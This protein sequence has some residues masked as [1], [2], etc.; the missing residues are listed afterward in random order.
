L[1]SVKWHIPF[2]YSLE[3]LGSK[4][5]SFTNQVNTNNLYDRITW[6]SNRTTHT[7]V[8]LTKELDNETFII[9]NLDM[10]GFYR[11]NYDEENWHLIAQQ[12][13][14]NLK[15]FFLFSKKNK[16]LEDPGILGTWYYLSFIIYFMEGN[17][18]HPNAVS[19]FYKNFL[20]SKNMEFGPKITVQIGPKKNFL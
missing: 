15:V 16:I 7:I 11:V 19:K 6:M 2:T 1:K 9:G 14:M 12:L 13:E 20:R 17:T 3:T 18:W 10:S 4:Q 8:E 5:P